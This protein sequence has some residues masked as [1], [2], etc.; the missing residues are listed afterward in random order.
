MTL[1]TL[2]IWVAIISVAGFLSFIGWC[3][4][5]MWKKLVRDAD[6]PTLQM[7][8][9]DGA[10]ACPYCRSIETHLLFGSSSSYSC[11]DCGR[12]WWQ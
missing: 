3:F 12:S 6:F 5:W 9:R 11:D 7:R 8:A 10:N 1:R 4:T 2:A